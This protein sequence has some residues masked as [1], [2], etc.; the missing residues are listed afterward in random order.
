MRLK[1]APAYAALIALFCLLTPQ[2]LQA[3]SEVSPAQGAGNSAVFIKTD[4]STQGNW[5]GKYGADG[6]NII[7]DAVA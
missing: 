2:Q 3:Q 4:A 7:R 6:Y 5:R 1:S